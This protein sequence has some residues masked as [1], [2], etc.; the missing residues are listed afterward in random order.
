MI[1]GGA[2]TLPSYTTFDLGAGGAIGPVR[3]DAVLTNVFDKTYYYSD[4]LSRYSLGTE[5]RV[6][7]GEPRSFSVRISRSFGGRQP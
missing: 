1:N 3:I 5:D 2:V 7:L 6:L 4:N